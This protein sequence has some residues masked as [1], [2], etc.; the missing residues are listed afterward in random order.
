MIDATREE[1][2]RFGEAR[3]HLPKGRFGARPDV[4]TLHRWATRGVHGVRLEFLRTPSGL[5]TSR[6]ALARF[7][8]RLT[9]QGG[10]QAPS[11]PVCM[12]PPARVRRSE[13]RAVAAGL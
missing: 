13:A 3:N 5:V 6:E 7:F 4:S 11:Q 1:L 2:L 8:E 10:E 12:V 9:S